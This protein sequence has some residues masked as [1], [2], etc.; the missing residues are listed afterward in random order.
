[1][2]NEA[3]LLKVSSQRNNNNNNKKAKGTAQMPTQTRQGTN[4]IVFP[5]IPAPQRGYAHTF[6]KAH[7]YKLEPSHFWVKVKPHTSKSQT[8]A[9]VPQFTSCGSKREESTWGCTYA[10]KAMPTLAS[11]GLGLVGPPATSIC[12]KLLYWS[13]A[14]NY[15]GFNPQSI[16]HITS[17]C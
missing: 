4:S 10:A 11:Q 9:S 3:I 17:K 16:F 5:V 2:L 15:L 13:W 7:G 12:H 1:M 6:S 14:Q 8:A